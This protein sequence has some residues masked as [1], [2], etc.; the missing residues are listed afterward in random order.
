MKQIFQYLDSGETKIIELPPPR[1]KRGEV[2]IRSK[3]SLISSGT[4]RM[5]I[6]FGKSNI[7]SKAKNQPE[8]V[9]EVITKIKSDGI[10]NTLEA[11]SNKLDKPLPLGYCNAG[12]VIQIGEG[13]SSFKVGDRVVSNG[14]H[15]ELV[16]VSENLCALI[17]EEVSFEDAAFT[18]IA[19]IGLQGIRLLKPTLGETI[20]VSGLGI[21]GLI[22]CQLLIANGCKVLG[23]D[24]DQSKCDLA[25]LFGV[26]TFCI[27]NNNNP[28][29]WC[30]SKTKEVGVDGFIVTASTTSSDPIHIAANSSRK[31]GRIILVG[32]TGLDL[33]RNLFYKKELTFQVSCSYGPGRYDKSYEVENYDYPIGFVRWTEKRNFEAILDLLD[34]GVLDFEKLIEKKYNFDDALDAYNLLLEK[35][36]SL[37]ILLAYKK[38][39]ELN[40]Y[41][42]KINSSADYKTSSPNEPVL[43]CIGAG[44]Y[45]SRTLLPAFKKSGAN[46]H[47]ICS[48]KGASAMHY[49]KKFSFKEVTTNEEEVFSNK[50]CNTVIISTRHDSHAELTK[51]ALLAGKNVFVEKPLCLNIN[52]LNSI[53][54]A[55][56]KIIN[57]D[58][59]NNYPPILMVGY[60]RR[61]SPLITKLK[62]FLNNLNGPKAFIYTCNSGFLDSNHW[63]N[64]P[65]I[66]GGRFLGECCHFVDLL[67]FLSQEKIKNIKICSPL[68]EKNSPETF[69]VN[70]QFEK[71]SIGSIHYFSNGSKLLPKERI[72]VFSDKTIF[73]LDNF[74]KLKAWGYKGFSSQRLLT[75]DKGQ[76]N[77]TS[78]FLN[79]IRKGESSPIP[80]EEIFEVQRLILNAK[81]DY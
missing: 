41:K 7:I 15:A 24:P 23:L 49:G 71:G 47:I 37:G 26:E 63:L 27:S 12:I 76:K 68:N 81:Y 48:L 6:N 72:E 29:N 50:I 64:D 40:S 53:E 65:N 16:T 28:T 57:Q 34:A 10:L 39:P 69:T 44:N 42:I 25:S 1:L 8:K 52:E 35:S 79:A 54:D 21:I 66:G 20:A 43:G 18:V 80:L 61:F 14:Y 38:E 11:V 60:N 55:Y 31:R 33:N 78:A 75:Q 22:T 74:K 59:K 56:R 9:S 58:D 3:F 4:E 5:L 77:C 13:V 36:S 19:S 45:S 62:K 32:V 51:R 2:L 67:Y 17:P 46:F 30:L 70:I 73:R